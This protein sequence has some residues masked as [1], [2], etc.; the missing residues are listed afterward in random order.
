MD[1]KGERFYWDVHPKDGPRIC[2]VGPY[3]GSI[4]IYYS[5]LTRH[6]IDS[7]CHEMEKAAKAFRE[8]NR[9]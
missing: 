6:E 8:W 5:K 9:G 3:G 2:I 7:L 1:Q 4:G